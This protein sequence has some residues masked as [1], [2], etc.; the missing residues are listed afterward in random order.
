MSVVIRLFCGVQVAWHIFCTL[1]IEKLPQ[2]IQILM[3]L[4]SPPGGTELGHP[5]KRRDDNSHLPGLGSH[6]GSGIPGRGRRRCEPRDAARGHGHYGSQQVTL[7]EARRVSRG[8]VAH[9]RG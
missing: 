3:T 5:P 4:S 1:P 6:A 2:Q 7:G 8:T 9:S